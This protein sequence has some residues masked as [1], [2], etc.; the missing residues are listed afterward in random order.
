MVFVHAATYTKAG[1]YDA[2]MFF[3]HA[4]AYTGYKPAM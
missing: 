4:A 1:E 3:V 2:S